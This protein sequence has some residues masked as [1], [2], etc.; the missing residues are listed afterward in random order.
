MS[1]LLAN[2]GC[3]AEPTHRVYIELQKSHDRLGTPCV[4]V[5]L[6]NLT[7]EEIFLDEE[8]MLSGESDFE[9]GVWGVKTNPKSRIESGWSIEWNRA[10]LKFRREFGQPSYGG[11]PAPRFIYVKPR[12]RQRISSMYIIA[13]P[14]KISEPIQLRVS[15]QPGKELE[16]FPEKP[17]LLSD[18]VDKVLNY[19]P[20]HHMLLSRRTYWTNEIEVVP[21]KKEEIRGIDPRYL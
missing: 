6:T 2:I 1:L 17:L 10:E 9:G 12:K 13:G 21:L 5:Y 4:D 7:D 14:K 15:Y 20:L 19:I 16:R 18:Q 3:R 11:D 8:V